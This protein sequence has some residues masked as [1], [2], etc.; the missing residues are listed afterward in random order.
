MTNKEI[1]LNMLAE[2]SATDMKTFYLRYAGHDEKLQRAVAL[3]M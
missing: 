1:A 2:A 3:L